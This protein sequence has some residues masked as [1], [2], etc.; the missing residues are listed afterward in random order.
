IVELLLL[1]AAVALLE[2]TWIPAPSSQVSWPVG[3]M[4]RIEPPPMLRAQLPVGLSRIR[5]KPVLPRI[6]IASRATSAEATPQIPP[7][8][9]GT[10]LFGE[11]EVRRPRTRTAFG[12]VSVTVKVCAVRS[13][14]PT[15]M[16]PL[17]SALPVL[18][19]RVILA[20][21]AVLRAARFTAAVR[22]A[23]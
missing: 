7:N 9:R 12:L 21:P 4:F 13:N 20:P 8:I 6:A 19:R 11:A 17:A 15:T 22:A 5:P 1:Q 2:F 16:S 3:K 23:T 14:R 10:L 18:A